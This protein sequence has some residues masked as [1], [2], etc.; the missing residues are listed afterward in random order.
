MNTNIIFL[1][2]SL[3]IL[4]LSLIIICTSPII[5]NIEIT[6]DPNN[7]NIW[8]PSKWKTINRKFF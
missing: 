6:I 4:A 2:I 5:N 7:N 1:S 8:K 3:G